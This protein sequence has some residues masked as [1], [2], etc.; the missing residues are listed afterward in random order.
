M[1]RR[2]NSAR[3]PRTT[4]HQIVE[5]SRVESAVRAW[6]RATLASKLRHAMVKAGRYRSAYVLG[7]IET[8]AIERVIELLRPEADRKINAN[9]QVQPSSI[10]R[11]GCNRVH[12]P[13]PVLAV[14]SFDEGEREAG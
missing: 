3:Q 8:K 7:E 5:G 13:A 12:S 4:F 9:F 14:E 6:E 11:G 2:A 1:K 10:R